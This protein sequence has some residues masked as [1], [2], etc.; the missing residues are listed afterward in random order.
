M[1][2]KDVLEEAYTTF[3]GHKAFFVGEENYSIQ[4]EYTNKQPIVTVVMHKNV[5]PGSDVYFSTAK[6]AEC[7]AHCMTDEQKRAYFRYFS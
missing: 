2:R 1:F 7:F 6:E 4:L 5:C 3:G